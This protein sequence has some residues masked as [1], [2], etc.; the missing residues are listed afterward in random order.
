MY[1]NL[2]SLCP[3]SDNIGWQQAH[4]LLYGKERALYVH[5]GEIFV[6]VERVTG[7][8]LSDFS[9][10]EITRL[11]RVSSLN[12]VCAHQAS[13]RF[14]FSWSGLQT[15]DWLVRSCLPDRSKGANSFRLMQNIFLLWKSEREEHQVYLCSSNSSQAA[16][17]PYCVEFIS[18]H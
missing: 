14:S 16:R 11:Q 4:R 6:R 10:V 2:S 9:R 7:R 17:M 8:E 15:L 12:Q 3:P 1:Y 5:W 13:T 18:V